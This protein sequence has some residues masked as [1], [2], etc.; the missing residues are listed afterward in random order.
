MGMQPDEPACAPDTYGLPEFFITDVQTETVGSNVR[1][2]C[3]VRRS[4]IVHWLYSCVIPAE[5]LLATSMN[6]RAA[7]EQAVSLMQLVGQHVNH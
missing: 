5:L 2:F 4:G 1:L 3:G 6:C 7:A